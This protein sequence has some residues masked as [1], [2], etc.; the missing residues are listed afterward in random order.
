MEGQLRAVVYARFRSLKTL[1]S[2]GPRLP[3]KEYVDFFE[4]IDVTFIED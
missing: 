4:W 1:R 2:G 3:V